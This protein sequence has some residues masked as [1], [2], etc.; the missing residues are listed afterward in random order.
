MSVSRIVRVLWCEVASLAVVLTGDIPPWLSILV[1]SL[2]PAIGLAP[3]AHSWLTKARSLSSM[4]AVAYLVFF[5]LDWAYFSGRLIFATVHLMFYLKLHVL[6]HQENQRDRN[7]LHL[8]CLFELVAAASMTV[9]LVFLLPLVAFVLL[10]ALVLVLEQVESGRE[11]FRVVRFRPFIGTAAVLGALVLILAGL[12]FVALPRPIYGGFRLGGMSGITFTGFSER[13]ELGDFEEIK[14]SRDVVMRVVT[15]ETQPVPP[16]WRGPAYDRYEGGSWSQSMSGIQ[17]L[18]EAGDGAFLLDRPS[19]APRTEVEVFLEPLDTDVLF[20]PPASLSVDTNEGFV[21][22]DPYKTVRSGRSARAGRRYAVGWRPS[23][24]P[25]TSPVGGVSRMGSFGRR[26]Y[27]QVPELSR[28]F[29]ELADTMVRSD[30]S[31]LVSARRLARYL[32]TTY[33]YTLSPPTPRRADPI[34]DF[35]FE[36]RA[37]HCEYFATA[38]VLMLR[39][40]GIPSRLVTG[41][42]QGEH[43][44]I[45]NYH[46][47][48]RSNAHAWVEVFD[49]QRGWVAFDPTP[50]APAGLDRELGL[51]TQSIDSI[52]MLWDM[53]VV[54]F[55]WERQRGVLGSVGMWGEWG[56][57]EAAR[58]YRFVKRNLRAIGGLVA[59]L[60]VGWL[61]WRSRPGRRWLL[62][63]RWPFAR[64]F[65]GLRRRRDSPILFYERIL[66]HLER[67]GFTKPSGQTPGEYARRWE[68]QLPGLTELTEIYYGVRYG[69][70][71]MSGTEVA[72]ADRLAATVRLAALSDVNLAPERRPA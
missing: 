63:F 32:D 51:F 47:V 27:T 61:V 3:G 12:V 19:G 49:T 1:L 39:S 34:E 29:H 71:E 60:F 10:G 64:W 4:V 31:P 68:E 26:L 20:L 36:A 8:I 58:A 21:F 45:G 42:Q 69:G 57:S 41:F 56:L 48:R 6:L 7:R 40:R 33:A 17:S 44:Q 9:S 2:I 23:A 59:A 25:G 24:P 13:V 22:I 30:E 37:G 18:P 72:R 62:R 53:Y 16:R 70:L 5:P 38:M 15:E 35:L 28:E 66:S 14:R 67:V 46:V 55:D 52:Q 50:P 11:E 43:N 65:S 54:A